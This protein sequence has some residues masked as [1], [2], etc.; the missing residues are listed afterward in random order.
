MSASALPSG[1]HE[2]L[3]RMGSKVAQDKRCLRNVKDQWTRLLKY[4]TRRLPPAPS[5]VCLL[6]AIGH[7]ANCLRALRCAPAAWASDS[8]EDETIQA[9]S[10]LYLAM[11]AY[12]MVIAIVFGKSTL[13]GFSLCRFV[14]HHVPAMVVVAIP[15]T[16]HDH[17][18]WHKF[19]LVLVSIFITQNVEGC[20]SMLNFLEQLPWFSHEDIEYFNEYR[21]LPAAVSVMHACGCDVKS[22]AVDIGLQWY[23]KGHIC[24][25]PG[26]PNEPLAYLTAAIGLFFV[27]FFYVILFI[28]PGYVPMSIGVLS[29][30]R[31]ERRIMRR[32]T[33]AHSNGGAGADQAEEKVD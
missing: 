24:T 19:R 5:W 22:L 14:V 15:T 18:D 20:I 16:H 29:G 6:G 11:Y 26:D 17:P 8:R 12:D 10:V 1:L 21:F 30:A 3:A 28:S 32:R 7:F 31:R 13:R 27:W 33:K 4:S 9:A 2:N 25:R 23:R